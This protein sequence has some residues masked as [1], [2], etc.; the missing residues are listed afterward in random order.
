MLYFSCERAWTAPLIEKAL[1]TPS[2]ADTGAL[3]DLLKEDDV[4]PRI[5]IV[6]LG[7][8]DLARSIAFYRD[9]LGFPTDV[10]EDASIAFFRTGGARLALYPLDHLAADIGPETTPPE[11]GFCGVTLAH[12]V[13]AK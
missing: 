2:G 9:G 1:A 4:E 11:R 10:K 7:V 5:S 12:N 3:R 13:R 8:R 6:T